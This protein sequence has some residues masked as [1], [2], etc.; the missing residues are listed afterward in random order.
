M[1]DRRPLRARL[2]EDEARRAAEKL[3]RE[4]PSLSMGEAMDQV[5]RDRPQL[6]SEALD[7]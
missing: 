5:L 6:Y 4:R 3:V 1:N 7:A 2:A